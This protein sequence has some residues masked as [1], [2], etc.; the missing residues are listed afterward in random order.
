M[1]VSSQG[2]SRVEGSVQAVRGAASP[3]RAGRYDRKRR[4]RTIASDSVS[5]T[6]STLPMPAWS[7]APPSCSAV[8]FSPAA[9]T[10]GGPAVNIWLIPRTI[11]E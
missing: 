10:T 5:T 7:S 11:R 6:S 4:A 8:T 1:A 9:A 3:A 2:S